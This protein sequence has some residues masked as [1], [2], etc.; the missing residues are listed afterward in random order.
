MMQC[1]RDGSVANRSTAAYC[2]EAAATRVG[3]C[4]LPLWLMAMAA[5]GFC[6]LSRSVGTAC[7]VF[8]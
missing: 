6:Q 2:M 4:S 3:T 5:R 7:R 8:E 1:S